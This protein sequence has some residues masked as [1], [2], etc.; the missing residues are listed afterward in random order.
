MYVLWN[1]T[2]PCPNYSVLY[3]SLNLTRKFQMWLVKITLK[4]ASYILYMYP[5][6]HLSFFFIFKFLYNAFYFENTPDNF[7]LTSVFYFLLLLIIIIVHVS[8]FVYQFLSE[9]TRQNI[10]G[11]KTY[12]H[13]IIYTIQTN[14]YAVN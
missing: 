4:D 7:K 2:S 13:N 10:N 12:F 3:G 11:H 14:L 5:R 6:I 1:E 9:T 8:L